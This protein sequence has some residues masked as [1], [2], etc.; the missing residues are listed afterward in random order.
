LNWLI[1]SHQWWW[2]VIIFASGVGGAIMRDR[3]KQQRRRRDAMF[4]GG[5]PCP[6]Q[7]RIK[8]AHRHD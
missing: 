4:P 3:R 7:C 8:V 5:K 1:G 6:P 2:I